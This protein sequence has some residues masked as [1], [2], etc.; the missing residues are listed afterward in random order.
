M[1]E[2]KQLVLMDHGELYRENLKKAKMDVT[3][4]LVQYRVNGYFDASNKVTVFLKNH[5]KEEKV[6]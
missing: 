2:G 6:C 5:W 4:F 1:I 3:E